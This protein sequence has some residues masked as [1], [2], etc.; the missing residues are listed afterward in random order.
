MY[1][2]IRRITSICAF[3]LILN[4]LYVNFAIMLYID[5][6]VETF[7]TGRS[8]CKDGHLLRSNLLLSR[9]DLEDDLASIVLPFV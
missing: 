6:F 4:K 1:T 3:V 9:S 8:Y 2:F 7:F 5:S